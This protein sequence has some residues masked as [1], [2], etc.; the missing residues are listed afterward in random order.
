MS[1]PSIIK[2]PYDAT[3]LSP[4][5]RV[6]GEIISLPRGTRDR[7]YGLQGGPFFGGSVV[8]TT[9]PG[10]VVLTRGVDYEILYQYQEATKKVGQPINAVIYVFNVAITGQISV[11]YQVIGGEFSSNVS[12]IQ[13]LIETLQI[14]NRTIVWDDILNKPITFPP[15]PHL[16]H[17]GD[18]YGMEAVIDAID[19]LTAA[20]GAGGGSVDLTD[21]YQRLDALDGAVASQAT[22][23][24]NTIQ[25][26]TL[27]QQQLTL[28]AQ[29]LEDKQNIAIK[30]TAAQDLLVG[31]DHVFMA[32]AN[33]RLPSVVGLP[34]NSQLFFTR[35][36]INIVPTVTV[37]DANTTV[38][39][40]GTTSGDGF[41]YRTRNAL[42]ATLVEPFVWEITN[43]N[44]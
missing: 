20:I 39:R 24:S 12:A 6:V 36:Q 19:R 16:H 7:A 29:E 37:F 38:V 4:F 28:R 3:G 5:N 10:N 30:I 21:I 2:Y 23:L 15:A 9:V 11:D 33:G 32:S 40:Y 43:D 13:A 44:D 35:R 34:L 18:L 27:L 42:K 31:R 14:D 1:S 26:M 8:V 25:A 41:Y 17:V 22:L